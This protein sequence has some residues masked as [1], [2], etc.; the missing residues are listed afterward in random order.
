MKTTT[1]NKL[2]RDKIPEI[3]EDSGKE[4]VCEILSDDQYIKMLNEKL[5]EEVNEY[6]ESGS[7]EELADIG[8]VMHAILAYKNVSIEEFQKVRIEKLEARGGFKNKI[9]LKE[10][11]EN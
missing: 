2:V 9:F 1:C 11:L 8:E 10:V 7:V 6:F 4:C 5:Q 3:I